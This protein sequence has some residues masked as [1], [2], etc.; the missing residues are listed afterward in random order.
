MQNYMRTI[1]PDTCCAIVVTKH[2]AR[3]A[4]V[5][6]LPTSRDVIPPAAHHPSRVTA[7][8]GRFLPVVLVLAVPA[9]ATEPPAFTAHRGADTRPQIAR[10]FAVVA[11]SAETDAVD[12]VLSAAAYRDLKDGPAAR[13]IE[14]P[15]GAVERITLELARFEVTTPDTRFVEAGATGQR[16]LPA[17]NLVLLRGR[18]AGQPQSHA[19]IALTGSGTGNGYIT[20]ESGERYFLSPS[21]SDPTQ[22]GGGMLSIHR[23]SHQSGLPEFPEFCGLD[24][25]LIRVS[26]VTDAA[27]SGPA[28]GGPRLAHVAVDADQAFTQLFGPE[29]RS[30]A[31]AYVVQVIGAISDIYMRDF[32]V[33][34]VLSFLR[35]WPFGGEPFGAHDL[36]GFRGYWINNEDMTGID[37]VHLFSGRR[38]LPYGGIAFLGGTCTTLEFAISGYMLGSFPR[39]VVGS[40]LG[41]WDLVVTA[42]EIGHNMGT[43]HTHD[44][45]NPPIDACASGVHS[46]GTIMS[47]CHT[48]AGGLL[49]IDMRFHARVQDVVDVNVVAGGCLW[50]DCNDNEIDDAYEIQTGSTDDLN[51]NGIPD[52]CEDCNGNG[53]R[54]DLDIAAGESDLDGNG[55]PDSCQADCN[56]NVWPDEYEVYHGFVQDRNGNLIPDGCEPD[57]DANGL[58]DH[59][60]LANGTKLDVD[61]NTVPDVC[62]DCNDNGLADWMDVDRQHNV[63]VANLGNYVREFHA[64]SGVG[65]KDHARGLVAGPIDLTFGPDNQLYVACVDS[66]RIMR[67]DVDGGLPSIFVEAG[68]GGLTAPSGLTFGPNGNLFVATHGSSAVLEFDSA[69]GAFAGVFV[70][71]GAGGLT[72]PYGLTF[73]PNGNLFVT[74][75]RH[76]VLEYSGM[77]GSFVGT[78]VDQGSGGLEEPRGLAFKPDGNLLVASHNTDEVIEYDAVGELVGVFNDSV[79]PTGA[80]GVRIGP[81]G[82]VFVVPNTGTKRIR[83]YDVTTGR[84]IRSFIRGTT[85]LLSPTALAFRPASPNDCNSNNAP[86]DCD[87][88]DGTS[89]DIN[90][91]GILDECEVPAEPPA[92][93]APPHNVPKNRYVTFDAST[94]AQEVVALQVTVASMKRCQGDL[95][96]TCV[97]NH[98]CPGVC[99]NDDIQSCSSGLQCSGGVCVPTSPCVRHSSVGLT[100]WIG[101]PY[102]PSCQ[103]DDGSPTGDPCA[104]EEFLARVVDAPVFRVWPEES[105]HVGDCEIVPVASYELRATIGGVVLG[106]PLTVATIAKPGARHYGDVAGTGT[107]DLPPLPGF[108]PPNGV[109]NVSDFHAYVLTNQGP[110]S[111]SVH[112]TWVDLHGLGLG[113]VPNYIINIADLQRILFGF[114]GDPYTREPSQL[115]PADC[116]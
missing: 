2:F 19:F 29:G 26:S 48:T 73:G 52:E 50:F 31:E 98:D 92:E 116:P 68:S 106:E 112:P 56:G 32:D 53:I 94:N 40:H 45:Y 47:Y 88:A 70:A 41:N 59:V 60:E 54:D 27:R 49:N 28:L 21:D 102:D 9:G 37:F 75:S 63:F 95:S 20:L 107:G 4:G 11:R 97:T 36:V 90:G 43:L 5:H 109:V 64:A 115:D 14:L 101:Q 80:W 57:C 71:S 74:S 44:G 10:P 30:N 18:V 33:K 100:R 79:T 103:N 87:L 86:D 91:N 22:V 113:S 15:L 55:M 81:N 8:V 39:P 38:D 24:D 114:A 85:G 65:I 7:L 84:Y 34:L 25:S 82:N 110:S 13:L 77:D 111:P 89:S 23:Q 108:T 69:T 58:P 1:P 51:T 78:F 46:R 105:L 83:E 12:V 42:H 96:R 67:V 104:G 17:P 93:A 16:E 3:W 72:G 66:G 62:Q 76:S 35:V 99:E 61:R 6:G